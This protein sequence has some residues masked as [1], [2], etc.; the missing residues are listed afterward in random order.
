MINTENELVKSSS[1]DST[2]R[3]VLNEICLNHAK[4]REY[5]S[6]KLTVEQQKKS[7]LEAGLSSCKSLLHES[8]LILRKLIKLLLSDSSLTRTNLKIISQKLNEKK[9]YF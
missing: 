7:N 1:T 6:A 4:F 8:D 9:H 3:K 5:V 2:S